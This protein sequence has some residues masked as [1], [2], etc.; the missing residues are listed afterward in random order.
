MNE[1]DRQILFTF[2]LDEWKELFEAEKKKKKKK[3]DKKI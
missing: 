3:N 2:G 1:E